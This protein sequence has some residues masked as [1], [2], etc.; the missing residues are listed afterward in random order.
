M[1][2][3]CRDSKVDFNQQENE[4]AMLKIGQWKLLRLKKGKERDW[5]KKQEHEGSSDI[6][7]SGP[8]HISQESQK[9]K[10]KEAERLCGDTMAEASQI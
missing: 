8:T 2:N 3:H 4:S 1:K 5:K 10:T 6:P 9:E 7:S